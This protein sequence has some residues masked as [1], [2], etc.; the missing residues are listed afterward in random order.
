MNFLPTLSALVLMS[1]LMSPAQ[2]VVPQDEPEAVLACAT[3]RVNVETCLA[4]NLPAADQLRLRQ[5][6]DARVLPFRQPLW[7]GNLR[8]YK[9]VGARST[10]YVTL[11][12]GTANRWK[13]SRA[14]FQPEP[15]VY[16]PAAELRA[17][18]P[19]VVR[20]S[21]FQPGARVQAVVGAPNSG[22][23]PAL[24]SGIIRPDGTAD[25][26]LTVPGVVRL[27][28]FRYL[29]ADGSFVPVPEHDS[30]LNDPELIVVVGTR[31]G[32]IKASTPA[33]PFRAGVRPEDLK[34]VHSGRLGFRHLFGQIVRE[35][36]DA[37]D[38]LEPA[39]PRPVPVMQARRYE[40]APQGVRDDAAY[41]RAL[42]TLHP[43]ALRL[44]EGTA[45]RVEGSVD[46][47]A[48]RAWRL[49]VPGDGGGLPV[50]VLL[51]AKEVWILQGSHTQT[52]LL[53]AMVRTLGQAK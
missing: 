9:L 42:A 34:A 28:A 41:V 21:G 39:A 7:A 50:Y 19:T 3:Q 14:A 10:L 15:R 24:A 4:S 6:Q 51:G 53:D 33:L 5:F 46:T 13:V 22:A 29:K 12:R 31:D 27:P 25:L 43:A 48:G 8:E 20:A 36:G 17:F 49:S 40:R 44:S 1:S 2:G 47:A 16:V 52:A 26:T 45:I 38:V 32:R 11:S 18:T 35:G 30:L 37:I 23:G